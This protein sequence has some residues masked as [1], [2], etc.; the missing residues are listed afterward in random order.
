MAEFLCRVADASGKSFT[1]T[2]TA[3]SEAELRQ[4][5]TEK[6]L[7]IYSVR[8]R[9][10]PTLAL[11]WPGRARPRF[12]ASDF[13]LF[14]QQFVTLIRAG[15]PILRSVELLAERSARPG[16]RA[17]LTDIRERVRGGASLSE[18]FRAQGLF[19]EVYISSLLAGERS[20]NLAG[21]LE[22]YIAYQRVTGTVRRR[23][24]TALVYPALLVVVAAGVLS[25]VT[26]FVI[27]RFAELYSEMNVSL[28]ALTVAVVT[29]ALN[30]RASLLVLLLVVAGAAVVLVLVGRTGGGAQILDRA[31]MK[32]PLIGDI[33]LKFRLAQFTRT[34]STLLAGGIPLVPSLEVS[35]G[36]M[37]SP[38]L[39][40][41]IATA[42]VGVSEGQSLHAALARTGI[43]PDLVTEMIEVGESTGALP[44]MLNS[45]AEFYDEDLNTR[46]TTLLA[47]VEPM[48]L[49]VMGGIILVI[50]VALYLPIFSIGSVV[51]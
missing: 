49:V 51:R 48:L 15:L 31:W 50:L 3:S 21:V 1:Q 18:G 7:Y 37:G 4:R 16:L 28:P 43:V 2:E 29:V 8:G 12:S 45:V 36:A 19:P 17:V 14:N 26:L 41:S 30:I 40:S 9:S 47:L 5:L 10:L 34:L 38:V 35:A 24:L 25:Y 13:F 46:L 6:G 27:P 20:G 33:I 22:Q 11:R 32:I 39:R 44:H 23:L 42:A